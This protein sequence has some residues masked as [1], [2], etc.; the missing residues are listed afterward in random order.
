M[1]GW[2][3]GWMN[4]WMDGRLITSPMRYFSDPQGILVSPISCA[5]FKYVLRTSIQ[6]WKSDSLKSYETF[7]PICTRERKNNHSTAFA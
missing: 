3:D 7:Q 4:V 6:T 5:L 1:N 2:I